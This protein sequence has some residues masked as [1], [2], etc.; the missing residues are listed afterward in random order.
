MPP[1]HSLRGIE[2]FVQTAE[3]GSFAKAAVVLG[4]TPVAVSE[5]ISRLERSLGV[6]LLAR[7]TRHLRLTPEGE[8]FL[9]QCSK[10]LRAL[11]DACRHT[12]SAVSSPQGLV[13]VT[14]VSAVGHLF[15]VPE[16]PQFFARYPG[17]SLELDL[18]EETSG[19]IA[20]RF[21]VGI[22]VGPLNDAA[23]VARPL[24]PLRLP[25]VASAA[26]LAQ[27]G[28][29]MVLDDL[30]S[31]QLL[32]QQIP[33]RDQR[34]WLAKEQDSNGARLRILQLPARLVCNNQQSLL[35]ACLD[36]LGIA[37]LPQPLVLP[38][39]RSGAL[40]QVLA[41]HAPDG[42]QI[43]LYYPS[44]KQLPA[45]VRAF[46]DFFTQGLVGHADFVDLWPEPAPPAAHSGA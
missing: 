34:F 46:V 14:M 18:N 41:Q 10:P 37:Q 16:L 25:M 39:L 24:G 5:N 29:P 8:A 19:L 15:V 3:S 32:Q 7:S 13:R 20:Q 2:N 1:V 6:R 40:R 23:F 28:A 11:A 33:G 43:Y 38:A 36:G 4:V 42:L 30:T 31:H 45:R 44:R 9:E 35:R 12:S 21:D 26:Y 17:I 22:R 27:H